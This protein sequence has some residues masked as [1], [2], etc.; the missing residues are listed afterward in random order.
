M[1][2]VRLKLREASEFIV[3]KGPSF[4]YARTIR[5]EIDGTEIYLKAPRHKSRL[6]DLKG[7]YP[8]RYYTEDRLHFREYYSEKLAALG[9]QDHFREANFL[10]NCWAFCGPWFTGPLAELSLSCRIVKI[11]NYPD[12]VSLFHPRALEQVIADHLSHKYGDYFE[13]S[14]GNKQSFNGPYE[15]LPFENFAVNGVRFI[16]RPLADNT[17]G[18]LNRYHC[19]FPL[20][21]NLVMSMLFWPNRLKAKTM[22]EMDKLVDEQ[23]M[24]DLMNNIIDSVRITLSPKAQAQQEAALAGLEDTSLTK[25]FPLMKWDKIGLEENAQYVEQG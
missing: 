12:G 23:P 20:A 11:I 25:N 17:S 6:Y 22:E 15:W 9:F 2:N 24:L 13:P 16:I 19:Y 4:R 8:E 7:E 10:Y 18:P 14:H 5:S 21:D 3:P 1:F